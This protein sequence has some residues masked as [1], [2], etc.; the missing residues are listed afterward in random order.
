MVYAKKNQITPNTNGH[1]DKTCREEERERKK[2]RTG[3]IPM[4]A[5]MLLHVVLAGKGLVTNRTEHTL[6][7]GV[8]LAMTSSMSGGGEGGRTVVT[9]RIRTGVFVLADTTAA[10]PTT[11]STTSG[12]GLGRR[13]LVA[14][15]SLAG[16]MGGGGGGCSGCGEMR[17]GGIGLD[18]RATAAGRVIERAHRGSG[19]RGPHRIGR[20]V[21]LES[22]GG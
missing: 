19:R 1:A 5:D 10:T 21:I 15:R 11:A 3:G 20:I 2:S 17:F 4:G 8:S 12:R 13:G 14:G 9:G 6:L 16:T 18:V 22:V 7:A